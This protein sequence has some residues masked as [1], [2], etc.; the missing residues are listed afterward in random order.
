M[1]KT[2][3]SNDTSITTL[4]K[5]I[6]EAKIQLPMFQRDWTWDDSRIKALLASLTLGY[7]MGAV[8]QLECGG[9]DIHFRTRVIEGVKKNEDSP[10]HLILDG[11]QRLTSMYRSIYSKDPVLTKTD[12]GKEVKRFYY[13]DINKC[14]DNNCDRYDAIISVPED[15]IVRKFNREIELD[16]STVELE[17]KNEMFPLNI[18]FDTNAREDWTDGYKSSDEHRDKYK[19]FRAEVMDTIQSYHIPVITLDKSTPKEAV[20]KVFE[21]VNTGGV[22][23]T[24]FELVTATFAINIDPKTNEYFDLRKDWEACSGIIRKDGADMRSDVLDA[25]DSTEFLAAITLYTTYKNPS[26]DTSCKKSD[27]LSLKYEDYLNNKD[28]VLIGYDMVREFLNEE[29]IFKSKDLPYKSQLI[30]LVVICAVI[31]RALF[32]KQ[33]TKEILKRWFWSGI[34]GELYAGTTETKAANDVEDVVNSILGKQSKDRT[35]N[36]AVFSSTRLLSL[37]TRQSAAYKGIMALLY[38][39]QAK[40]FIGGQVMSLINSTKNPDIHHIFPQKYCERINLQKDRWNSIINKTPLLP[41]SNRS[42]GGDAPSIYLQKIV[43]ENES[44]TEDIL[45]ERVESNLIDY[46]L[47]ESNNF[48][49]YFIDRAKKLLDMIESTGIKI[50][51]RDSEATILKFGESLSSD[52]DKKGS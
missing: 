38:K 42:I 22:V 1:Q 39:Q 48:D 49:A 47:L 17:Y 28:S 12:T 18:L 37:Q 46:K 36:T 19:K 11:Q 32:N 35:I 24:V 9:D 30:P 2:P 27:I 51:D 7:P 26:A 20:C 50:H 8:M 52:S 14:L 6:H 43:S 13:L 31:G 40:D 29:Y 34:L 10:T 44:I 4:L 41:E 25:I 21:N 23:L 45:K 3:K 5:D 16:L 33:K 15:K